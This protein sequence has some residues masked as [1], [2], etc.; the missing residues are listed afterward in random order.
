LSTS[1]LSPWGKWVRIAGVHRASARVLTSLE[2]RSEASAIAQRQSAP[3]S[4]T[5]DSRRLRPKSCYR[6]C[7]QWRRPPL[8]SDFRPLIERN[9]S[10]T[11]V[12][13]LQCDRLRKTLAAIAQSLCREVDLPS[14]NASDHRCCHPAWLHPRVYLS[15][16]SPCK[17][18][19][20]GYGLDLL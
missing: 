14:P 17:R 7:P 9:G 11:N 15:V 4:S 2:G 10:A 20:P 18:R 1:P 12:H 13:R 6:S 8:Q 19:S 16:W 3:E 5:S